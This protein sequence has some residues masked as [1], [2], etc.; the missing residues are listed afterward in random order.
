MKQQ[1][2]EYGYAEFTIHGDYGIYRPTQKSDSYVT[3]GNGVLDF[4]K[5]LFKKQ[6]IT[7]LNKAFK[8]MTDKGTKVYWSFAPC[9]VNGLS[10]KSRTEKYQ[11]EY[12][13]LIDKN[14]DSIRISVIK[15]YV[16]SGKYFHDTDY[17]CG[18]EGAQI[19]T[20]QLASDFMAQIEREKA[21][22]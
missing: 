13:G 9:N 1:S 22:G 12:M 16:L 21:G 8:M 14:Y 3:F 6:Q 19:R 15:D 18:T 10:E 20:R 17:H 5:S 4:N 11:Q 7:S 2:Y